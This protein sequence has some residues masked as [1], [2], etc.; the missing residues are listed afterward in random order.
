M[1]AT[2]NICQVAFSTLDAKAMKSW[3][4]RAFGLVDAS[5][6]VFGGPSTSRVQ[7]L[8]NVWERC[9]WLV[10]SQHY[11]QLE[12][13]QFWKPVSKPRPIDWRP[14]D[15]GYNML[16]I[17]VQDFDRT[18]ESLNTLGSTPLASPVGDAGDRRVCVKDPEGNLVEIHESDPLPEMASRT[19]RPEVPATVRCMTVSVPDLQRARYTWVDTLG[20]QPLEDTSLHTHADAALWNVEGVRAQR[21]LVSSGNFLIELVQYEETKCRAWPAGYRICDQGFMNLAI[22]LPDTETFNSR[23]ECAVQHGMWANGKPLDIGVFKVMYVNDADGFSVELLNARPKLWS[24]SGFNPGMPYV[25]NEIWIDA[26]P[27]KVWEA[28]TDHAS[29]GDWSV[30]SSRLLREGEGDSN[31]KGAVRELK[32]LGLKFTEEVTD[33]QPVKRYTYRLTGGAP[34][35]EHRGDVLLSPKSDG[36]KVRWAIR[37]KSKIPGAGKLTA[38]V[39]QLIF[40]KALQRLKQQLE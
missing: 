18:L 13:F 19:F 33:W 2:Q 25:E 38:L 4:Q 29:L 32:G 22:G 21:L 27:E 11:F 6:T 14:T 17:V 24:L 20:M 36:T 5:G 12:F 1:T 16:G 15:I 39:L 31:G 37:F 10:D 28:I 7:G 26:S 8:P 30:F 9:L 34:I 23:F 35:K 3:Y 40:G